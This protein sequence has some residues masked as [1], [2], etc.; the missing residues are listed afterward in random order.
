MNILIQALNILLSRIVLQS[1]SLQNK[2]KNK[3][4]IKWRDC[5]SLILWVYSPKMKGKKA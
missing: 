5:W 2:N 3:K 4:S 1:Y